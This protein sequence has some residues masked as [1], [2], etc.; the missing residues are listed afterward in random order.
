MPPGKSRS[1]ENVGEK[2]MWHRLHSWLNKT[3]VSDPIDR[4]YVSFMQLLFATCVVVVPAL[5]LA[6][7][8]AIILGAP[9]HREQRVDQ[10]LDLGTDV[11]ITASACFGIFLSMRGHF[12][13]SVL[14]F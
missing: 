2:I 7:Y 1:T 14:Q 4:H 8:V 11:L 10:I 6:Y 5:K 9:L 13:L 12:R 3:P